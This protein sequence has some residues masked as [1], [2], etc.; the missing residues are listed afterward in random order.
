MASPATDFKDYLLSYSEESTAVIDFTFGTNLFVGILPDTSVGICH[1]L[2]DLPGM[3]PEP[4]GIRLPAVQILTRG[5][6]GKYTSAWNQIELIAN[7][8][9]ELTNET[10][11]STRYIQI[12]KMGDIAHVGN[13][14]KGRPIFSCTMSAQRTD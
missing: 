12:R 11:S 10:I 5:E 9:H 2:F 7:L 14:S 6:Q 4:N 1:C 3:D 8:F 13:D